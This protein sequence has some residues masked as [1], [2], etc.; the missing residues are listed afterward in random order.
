M[1]QDVHSS[2][3]F[4]AVMGQNCVKTDLLTDYVMAIHYGQASLDRPGEEKV[5]YNISECWRMV[6]SMTD[7]A[8]MVSGLNWKKCLPLPLLEKL[9]LPPLFAPIFFLYLAHQF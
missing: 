3:L 9:L 2:C 4:V 7:F 8:D 1:L 6:A 5:H